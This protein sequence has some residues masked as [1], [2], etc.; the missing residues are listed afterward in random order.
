MGKLKAEQVNF[1]PWAFYNERDETKPRNACYQSV[2]NRLASLLLSKT[3][4]I[5]TSNTDPLN[6]PV[7][8]YGYE[9]TSYFYGV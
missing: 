3:V 4:S 5:K 6:L 1:D 2:Q 8:L 7:V 9:K